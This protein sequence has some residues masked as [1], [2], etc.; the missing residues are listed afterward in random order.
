MMFGVHIHS[1][2]STQGYHKV[3]RKALEGFFLKLKEIGIGG[4]EIYSGGKN[5]ENPEWENYLRNLRD[6]NRKYG[7]RISM[8][9]PYVDLAS[10]DEKTRKEAVNRTLKAMGELEGITKEGII[11]IH[12]EFLT[13]VNIPWDSAKIKKRKEKA[14]ES[15]KVISRASEKFNLRIALENQSSCILFFT[16]KGSFAFSQDVQ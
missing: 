7:T 16:F 8:H 11:V 15:L 14:I 3:S 13:E 9:A 4:L 1:F 6:L 2:T 12:P 10:T 5:E